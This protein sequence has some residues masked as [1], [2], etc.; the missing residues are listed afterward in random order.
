VSRLKWVP[1]FP[2]SATYPVPAMAHIHTSAAHASTCAFPFHVS[3][4]VYNFPS[5]PIL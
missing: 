5:W 3:I 1:L 4:S 2:P